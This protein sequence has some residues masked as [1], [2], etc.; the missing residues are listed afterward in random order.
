MELLAAFLAFLAVG[1]AAMGVAEVL[2]ARRRLPLPFLGPEEPAARTP[3]LWEVWAGLASS[4]FGPGRVAALER[5]LVWAG[6]PFGWT[7]EQMAS[8]QV[9][10]AVGAVFLLLPLGYL[11]LG[12]GGILFAALGGLVGY[13]AP[14]AIVDRRV[15]QRQRS[16]ARDLTT[17]IDLI[18]VGVEAGMPL[19]EAMRQVALRMPEP[20]RGELLRTVQEMM[21]STR[22]QALAAMAERTG[23][24]E[25]SRLAWIL[26]QGARYGT[27]VAQTLRQYSADLRRIRGLDLQARAA[28]LPVLMLGP[29]FL[30]GLLPLMIII[31][32]PVVMQLAAAFRM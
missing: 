18:A 20:L 3:A 4:L 8:L 31:L 17:A 1:L 11:G 6:R 32:G 10:A 5:K 9:G 22:E 28:S 16:L 23:L 14:Q 24:P 25:V 7:G 29:M 27:P 30:F 19:A 21:A 26:Q 15:E 2:Q 13:M 12:P